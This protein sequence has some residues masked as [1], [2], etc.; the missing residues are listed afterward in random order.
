MLLP[1]DKVNLTVTALQVGEGSG[2]VLLVYILISGILCDGPHPLDLL[3][4]ISWR[5]QRGQITSVLMCSSH[6]KPA[7]PMVG[8]LSWFVGLQAPREAAFSFC[9][10]LEGPGATAHLYRTRAQ[11]LLCVHSTVEKIFPWL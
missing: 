5:T 10:T 6:I 8:T 9:S 4:F 11:D 2:S 7:S 1:Q 3:P